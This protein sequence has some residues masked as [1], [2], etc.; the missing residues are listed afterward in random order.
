MP[1]KEHIEVIEKYLEVARQN[2]KRVEERDGMM[3]GYWHWQVE[4]LETTLKELKSSKKTK[5]A[6]VLADG[7]LE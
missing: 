4:L 7:K 3:N 1:N 2:V 5:K 6:E